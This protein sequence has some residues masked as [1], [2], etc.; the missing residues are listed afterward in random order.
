MKQPGTLFYILIIILLVTI[1]FAREYFFVNINYQLGKLFYQEY[2]NSFENTYQL[3]QGLSFFSS[4]KYDTLYWFKYILS[5]IFALIYFAV[6]LFTLKKMFPGN[7]QVVRITLWAHAILLS[8]ALIFFA[9]A[10]MPGSLQKGYNLSL[11][12]MHILQSPLVLMVLVP[13]F[14]LARFK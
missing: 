3:P 8:L 14:K 10:Y 1:G 9:F 13:A 5:I 4:W 2:R 11:T 12:F 6:T 7:K